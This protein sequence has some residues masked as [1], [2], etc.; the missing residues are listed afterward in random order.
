MLRLL[1]LLAVTIAEVREGAIY[2]VLLC[3][4]A[5]RMHGTVR[6]MHENKYLH[7]PVV[8]EDSGKVLGVVSV[9]EVIHATAGE[10]G[11]DRRV[12]QLQQVSCACVACR[13][14]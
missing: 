2:H 14:L 9:M 3:G 12:Q 5:H 13:L 7:L 11:S 8:E 4:S 6:Q 10:K 1:S